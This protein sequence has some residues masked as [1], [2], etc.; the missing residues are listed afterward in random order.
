M[1]P[2][3]PTF[4]PFQ[5]EPSASQQSSMSQ[6]LCL[7]AEGGDGVEIEDVAE[8]VGDHDGAGA[9]AAGGFELGDVDLVGGQRDVDE[10][11]D[12]AVLE[13]GVDRGR[14]AGGDGDDLIAGLELA[15]R[16][17]WAR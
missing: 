5:V 8:G 15:R 17:A 16:R 9:V 10:D 7:L 11:R 14:E 12:E 3:V 1:S 13:D 2:K 6:S 4:W